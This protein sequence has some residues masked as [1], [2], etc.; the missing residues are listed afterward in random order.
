MVFFTD[1]K[2]S[3]ERKKLEYFSKKLFGSRKRRKKGI[4]QEKK[5][6]SVVQKKWKKT[7]HGI[8]R[9]KREKLYKKDYYSTV[10]FK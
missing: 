4:C 2:E 9:E 8:L 5:S 6:F 7:Q 3:R 10:V 1:C